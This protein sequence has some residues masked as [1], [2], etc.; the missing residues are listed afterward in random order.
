MGSRLGPIAGSLTGV[1]SIGLGVYSV[2]GMVNAKTPE[3]RFEASHG[4]AWSLQGLAGLLRMVAP[5][6]SWLRGSAVHTV[7]TVL[8]VGG[9]LL[10]AGLGGYRLATGLHGHD[11]RR[12]VLGS[13]DLSAGLCWA[14]SACAL[15]GPAAMAGFVG[16][17][18][19]R[20]GYTYKDALTNTARRLLGKAPLPRADGKDAEHASGPKVIVTKPTTAAKAAKASRSKG[21]TT[22]EG[23]NGQ[24]AVIAGA[25][26]RGPDGQEHPA[27]VVTPVK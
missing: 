11:R 26:V 18:A 23:N 6:V 1:G 3:K 12:I 20:I 13:L 7:G 16:L 17:T 27:V 24:K 8:G 4:L 15:G 2:R 21:V 22:I 5:K 9:G 14:A 10:Q 25:T 19:A